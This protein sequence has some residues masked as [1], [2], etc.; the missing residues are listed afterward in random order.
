MNHFLAQFAS[1]AAIN[2]LTAIAAWRIS[3]RLNTGSPWRDHLLGAIIIFFAAVTA[4]GATLGF[5]GNITL[6]NYIMAATAFFTLSLIIKPGAPPPRPAALPFCPPPLAILIS[7]AAISLAAILIWDIV[8]PPPP[9][10]DAFIYHLTFPASW[11]Q[12]QRIFY[13]QLPYGAQ[14]A[15]YYPLN[16]ELFYLWLMIPWH[17]D[18]MINIAQIPFWIACAAGVTALALETR[19]HRTGAVAAGALVFLIPGFVQQCTVARVDIA[20]S[21][22]L[23]LAIYFA[24]RWSATRKAAHL[25]LFAAA[26]GMLAGTKSIGLIYLPIPALIF[27]ASLRGRRARAI[28]DIIICTAVALATGGFWFLR[29]WILLGNPMFPLDVTLFGAHIFSGA[30]GKE[31]MRAFHTSDPSH[32]GYIFELFLGMWLGF[33]LFATAGIS[34]LILRHRRGDNRRLFILITPT[35]IALLFW[36]VN[37]HNNLTNGRFLFPAFVLICYSAAFVL[38]DMKGLPANLWALTGIAAAIAAGLHP[39]SDHLYRLASDLIRTVW[40]T[41]NPLILSFVPAILLMTAAFLIFAAAL[42]ARKKR[43]LFHALITVAIAIFSFG[44][45]KSW[46][47]YPANRF[48][49]VKAFPTGAA[50]ATLDRMTKGNSYTIASVGNERM[51]GLFGTGFRHRVVT[52]NINSHPDWGFEHYW[53]AARRAARTPVNEERP[54]WHRENPSR[55]AWIANLRRAGVDIVFATTLETIEASAMQHDQ[56]GFPIEVIW[57]DSDPE[58]FRPLYANAEVRIYAFRK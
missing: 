12:E 49:W 28:A 42:A 3:R 9:G 56:I 41:G 37:P 35:L 5:S 10:G 38:N 51:Y 54:Q 14:A 7:L 4:I 53:R 47:A 26:A 36:Y 44:I 34:A 29:N 32:L 21:A 40:G 45:I 50:W 20:F 19:L 30:Y 11:L 13:V 18:F 57:A 1:F 33:Y 52:V 23:V 2:G 43:F 39:E 16:T 48:N 6:P 22:W 55:E 58:L 25:I 24:Y 8:T 27:L 15:S 46:Q 31:A 17:D